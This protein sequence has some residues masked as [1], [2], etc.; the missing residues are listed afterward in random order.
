MQDEFC[1]SKCQYL[2]GVSAEEPFAP[3]VVTYQSRLKDIDFSK[4]LKVYWISGRALHTSCFE[5]PVATFQS[6]ASDSGYFSIEHNLG[7]YFLPEL[8]HLSRLGRNV[9]VY[10]VSKQCA[11]TNIQQ[12]LLP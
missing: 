8:W 2:R 6:G 11:Q 10:E 9:Y 5:N 3:V 1:G 4:F 12:P 7:D